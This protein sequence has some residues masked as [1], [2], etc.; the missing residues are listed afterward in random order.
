[1][2]ETLLKSIVWREGNHYIA[3]CLPVDVS[4]FGESKSEALQNL[5]EA[6]ALYFEDLPIQ[7]LPSIT[8]PEIV[9][10]HVRYA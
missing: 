5:D 10:A 1:M 6:L 4:S 3:Q 9:E 8:E 2:K 7:G